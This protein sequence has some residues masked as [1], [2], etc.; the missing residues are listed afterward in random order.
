MSSC[1]KRTFLSRAKALQV[2][3][4]EPSSALRDTASLQQGAG[5]RDTD[6][7]PP[8]TAT[9]SR[10]AHGANSYGPGC[11]CLGKGGAAGLASRFH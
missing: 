6:T 4:S 3:S 1:R 2:P 11:L 8:S 9:R 7:G 10:G 5:H